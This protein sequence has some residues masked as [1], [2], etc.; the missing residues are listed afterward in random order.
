MQDNYGSEWQ[1][2]SGPEKGAYSR[3]SLSFE[4]DVL[5]SC[6]GN[7]VSM[8]R[9]RHVSGF[10]GK[11]FCGLELD[12]LISRHDIKRV[13]LGLT[14][15][16]TSS[17]FRSLKW[18]EP[19]IEAFRCARHSVWVRPVWRRITGISFART[20]GHFRA[21]LKKYSLGAVS[22]SCVLLNCN[23]NTNEDAGKAA[24]C[25]T[26]VAS[27]YRMTTNEVAGFK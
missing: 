14:P 8:T 1:S 18:D 23:W 15:K 13:G 6:R 16:K 4:G 7:Q 2:V 5:P 19:R 17:F 21:L 3:C 11:N 10:S 25:L 20:T 12:A 9:W 24:R 26:S 27:G 22:G